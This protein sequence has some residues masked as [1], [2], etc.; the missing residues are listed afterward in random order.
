VPGKLTSDLFKGVLEDDLAGRPVQAGQRVGGAQLRVDEFAPPKEP[1]QLD[2]RFSLLQKEEQAFRVQRLQEGPTRLFRWTGT[3][4][5]LSGALVVL[6]LI[7][8]WYRYQVV[9]ERAAIAEMQH[10]N[11]ERRKAEEERLLEIQRMQRT[12]P[13]AAPR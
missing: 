12:P 2:A 7:A 11:I 5:L 1:D 13:P 8:G 3:A 4:W 6:L 9:M 10:A